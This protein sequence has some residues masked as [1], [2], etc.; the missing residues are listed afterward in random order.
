M[1]AVTAWVQYDTRKVANIDT[2]ASAIQTLW[3]YNCLNRE[4]TL[5]ESTDLILVPGCKD[6][7]IARQA[8]EIYQ[9]LGSGILV[10]S[11]S[12]GTYT[13]GVFS[14]TEAE[15]FADAAV[16]V[17]VPR[18]RIILEQQACNTGENIRFTHDLLQSMG[19]AAIRSV[20]LV[21]K[22]FIERRIKATFEA[23]WPGGGNVAITTSSENLDF[24]GYCIAKGANPRDVARQVV[25]ATRRVIDY[26][27]L[28]FQTEQ[29]M[30]EEIYE[31]LLALERAGYGEP[32]PLSIA[33]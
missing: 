6:L 25:G 13:R 9:K 21:Q 32:K 24:E 28:G 12:Y 27:A 4:R 30:P 23:Q 10:M 31:T 22:P 14:K 26:P 15:M 11:G 20:I 16:D 33:A 29:D 8:A 18:E 19:V 1:L 5:P 2:R 3:D 17:G 7:G